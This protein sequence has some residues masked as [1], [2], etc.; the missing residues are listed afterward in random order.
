MDCYM[1]IIDLNHPRP[2]LDEEHGF[3]LND[4]DASRMSIKES[5]DELRTRLKPN[6]T[7]IDSEKTLPIPVLEL[8]PKQTEHA[9]SSIQ[10]QR[11]EDFE[12]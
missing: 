10:I 8:L 1:Q 11:S 6:I 12:L 4:H 5:L 9:K 7:A 2:H 3:A